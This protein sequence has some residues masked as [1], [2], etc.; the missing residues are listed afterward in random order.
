MADANAPK[1][2][3]SVKLVL[4]GEAAVGKVGTPALGCLG[5]VDGSLVLIH[6]PVVSRPTV[7]EQRLPRKQGA[8]DRRFA[9]LQHPILRSLPEIINAY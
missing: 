7:C 2:S 4:L 3:S 8:N 1:P 6:V 9:G 5:T